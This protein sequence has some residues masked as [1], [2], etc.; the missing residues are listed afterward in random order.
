MER[1]D[2]TLA[3][4]LERANLVV[5]VSALAHLSGD[6]ALLSRYPV[7]K[8]ER[9]WNAGGF[10]K[11]EKAE[12]RAHALEILRSLE[13]LALPPEPG[14]DELV[15]E[16]MQFC[17][18]EPIDEAYLPLVREECAFGG[19]DLRRFAWERTPAREELDAFRVGIIGSG[20]GGL[21]S[22]IRASCC[23]GERPIRSPVDIGVRMKPGDT[24]FIRTPRSATS[25][26]TCRV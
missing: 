11:Q 23:S 4:A 3:D 17:A 19:A 26:A 25:R 9:G 1:D 20:F 13:P 10:S 18:G 22:A 14:D 7:A 21:C 2:L 24:Q 5:L 6:R 12:I 16:I 8:F 15:F